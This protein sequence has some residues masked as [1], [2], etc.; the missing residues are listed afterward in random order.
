MARLKV[1]LVDLRLTGNT[2][3]LTCDFST[4]FPHA[5]YDNVG[6]IP[7]RR[8]FTDPKIYVVQTRTHGCRALHSDDHRPRRSRARSD[9]RLRHDR[10]CRRAMGAAL[11]HDRHL[12]GRAWRWRARGSWGRAIRITCSPTAREGSA[13]KARSAAPPPK[14]SA[15]PRRHPPRL[16]LR[17]GAAHH[18]EI[19]RQQRRDRRDLGAVAGDAGAAAGALNAALAAAPTRSASPAAERAG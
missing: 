13:R 14:E 5:D 2:L 17:A 9:L 6:T 7:V 10:L 4:I 12:A 1:E 19:D 3:S 11:D 8:S 15:D 16:C 18:A